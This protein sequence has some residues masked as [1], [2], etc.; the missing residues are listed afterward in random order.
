MGHRLHPPRWAM[1]T[2]HPGDR[3]VA[4]EAHDRGV[5]K[6]NWDPD[7]NWDT[8]ARSHHI[9]GPPKAW[10]KAHGWPTPFFSFRSVFLKKLLE[11]DETFDLALAESGVR[12]YIPKAEHALDA[13]DLARLDT[14]YEARDDET[15]RPSDWGTLVEDLREIR[16][17]VEAGVVVTVDSHE[18]DSWQAFYS[19]AHGRYGALED[20]SDSWIGDDDS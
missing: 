8:D 16:R 4:A 19:W 10:A 12:L 6:T 1:R 15:G 18:L 9:E 11:S 3:D 7:S 17:A 2:A 5:L 14:L 13:A 20:G